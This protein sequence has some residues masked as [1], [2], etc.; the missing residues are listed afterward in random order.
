MTWRFPKRQGVNL[1]CLF[2]SFLPIIQASAQWTENGRHSSSKE[3]IEK[4]FDNF[5]QLTQELKIQIGGLILS[6]SFSTHLD[7]NTLDIVVNLPEFESLTKDSSDLVTALFA[8]FVISH[9]FAHVMEMRVFR[10]TSIDSVRSEG[11]VYL[12]CYADVLSGVYITQVWNLIEAPAWSKNKGFNVKSYGNILASKLPSIYRRILS[13]KKINTD[14]KTHPSNEVRIFALQIGLELGN[15]ITLHDIV[16]TPHKIGEMTIKE[17]Q[18]DTSILNRLT[19]LIGFSP[20]DSSANNNLF[21]WI[22]KEVL[23]ITHGTNYLAKNLIVYNKSFNWD[24][25]FYN[26]KVTYSFDVRNNNPD[27]VSFCGRVYTKIL[28]RSNTKDISFTDQVDSHIFNKIICPGQT[29]TV[30]GRIKWSQDSNWIAEISIPGDPL[31]LYWVRPVGTDRYNGDTSLETFEPPSLPWNS[32]SLDEIIDLIYSIT[33][34]K[35]DLF[36]FANGVGRSAALDAGSLDRFPIYYNSTFCEDYG[37]DHSIQSWSGSLEY[38]IIVDKLEKADSANNRFDE[39]FN[40]IKASFRALGFNSK[41]SAD[42]EREVDFSDGQN[43]LF[44]IRMSFCDNA[45]YKIELQFFSRKRN[46]NL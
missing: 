39:I 38:D 33:S 16:S 46:K 26:A 22:R 19:T 30:I 37:G 10:K 15:I 14:Y 32:E 35:S 17:F 6:D 29:A 13:F 1:I 28:P 23:L 24:T 42:G 8:N 43:K 11:S 12:E 41:S 25:S 34:N 21:E 31:S 44:G 5:R 40:R 3:I 9:E 18:E 20:Q 4:E 2:F 36:E 27:T 7:R 45:Q